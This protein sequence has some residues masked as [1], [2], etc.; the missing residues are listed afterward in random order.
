MYTTI[1]SFP[2]SM[3]VIF[4]YWDKEQKVFEVKNTPDTKVITHVLVF[5][6]KL[7]IIDIETDNNY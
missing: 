1:Y 4:N 3:T 2:H 6:G 5:W 7:L